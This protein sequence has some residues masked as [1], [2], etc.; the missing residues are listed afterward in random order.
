MAEGLER[1]L[2]GPRLPPW[3]AGPWLGCRAPPT[4]VWTGRAGRWSWCQ[5]GVHGCCAHSFGTLVRLYVD[6]RPPLREGNEMPVQTEM[7][8]VPGDGCGALPPKGEGCEFIKA[9]VGKRFR[10]FRVG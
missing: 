2:R 8:T 5:E 7:P 10:M 3:G 4:C 6:C 9:L 1:P